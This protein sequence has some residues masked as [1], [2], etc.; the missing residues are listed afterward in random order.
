METRRNGTGLF[1]KTAKFAN[2]VKPYLTVQP[3]LEFRAGKILGFSLWSAST[4][5]KKVFQ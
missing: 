4:A 2:A 3:K 5:R 1:E